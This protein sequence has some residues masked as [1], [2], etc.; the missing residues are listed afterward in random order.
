MVLTHSHIGSFTRQH[1]RQ[2]STPRLC[3]ECLV[4][5]TYRTPS[6]EPSQGG[7]KRNP[8]C[9]GIPPRVIPR[10][11]R[12]LRR[13]KPQTSDLRPGTSSASDGSGQTL[14]NP[15]LQRRPQLPA[16][17]RRQLRLP[18]PPRCRH[19]RAAFLGGRALCLWGWLGKPNRKPAL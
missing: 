17:L 9:V 18:G 12:P 19:G 7:R 4:T 16:Q 11:P 6:P 2:T 14:R 13:R 15:S 5:L 10:S 1:R 3:V 8:E